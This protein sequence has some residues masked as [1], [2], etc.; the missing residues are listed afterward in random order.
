LAARGFADTRTVSERTLLDARYQAQSS[1][2]RRIRAALREALAEAEKS[3][4]DDLVLAVDE[5]CQNVI[6]HAYRGQPG[7][8][9]IELTQLPGR[10]IVML[11]DDA[12]A[13]PPDVLSRGRDLD[14]IRPGGLGTHFIRALM[15][16]LSLCSSPSGRGN[17]LRMVKRLDG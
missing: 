4:V 6:R 12:P 1:E 9:R 14:E 11:S 13:S 8:I 15:D 10:I 17:C 2:L 5:A 3:V 16:E 7:E